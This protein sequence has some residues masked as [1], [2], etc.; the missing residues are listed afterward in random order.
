[1]RE[2]VSLRVTQDD[3]LPFLFTLYC[4]VRSPEVNAWGWPASQRDSFL[5]MQF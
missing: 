2:A 4:D 1:M 3:D 5:R